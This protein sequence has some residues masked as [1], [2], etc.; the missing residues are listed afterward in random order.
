M[1]DINTP[2]GLFNVFLAAIT[3]FIIF[4]FI[5]KLLELSMQEEYI[6][7]KAEKKAK[8]KLEKSK[9]YWGDF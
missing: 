5:A 4:C 1:F 3:I 7:E 6:K 9:D 2:L 8:K